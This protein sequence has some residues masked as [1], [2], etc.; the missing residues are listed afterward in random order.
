MEAELNQWR[1]IPYSIL[2]ERVDADPVIKE[3]RS[4]TGTM[5]QI[6]VMVYWDARPE[7]NIRVIGAVDD[8]GIRAFSPVCSD[9]IK[10]PDNTFVGE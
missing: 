6:E 2:S 8:G 7:G 3:V 1:S 4:S 10:A 5:Y 9:F